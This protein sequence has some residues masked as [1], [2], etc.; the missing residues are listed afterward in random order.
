VAAMVGVAREVRR[1]LR[2]DGTFWLNI[3][4]SY[5]A[6]QLVGIPWRV[7]LALQADG[8][9]LRSDVI[10]AKPNPMPE[11]VTDRPTKAHEYVFLLTKAARYYYDAEAIAERTNG[12]ELFGNTRRL[13]HDDL[14]D[15]DRRDMTENWSRNARSVWTIATSPYPE[16]HFATFPKELP[17]RCIRAGTPEGGACDRC[18]TPRERVLERG[19]R[20]AEQQL[21]SGGSLLGTYDGAPLKDY[22]PS[23]AQVPGEVKARILAGMVEKRT[24]G[25]R[26]ACGC[27]GAGTRPAIVLDPF[28]GS[29]TT[30][31]AAQDLD[32]W[33]VGQEL[34]PEY[35]ALAERRCA[36]DMRPLDLAPW[37]EPDHEGAA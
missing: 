37:T 1:V 25:W 29:G 5:D 21:A 34:N 14:N 22:A 26:R 28:A 18:G 10:W 15:I 11:S 36:R 9:Y 6:K 2:S 7:A 24:V 35:V 23:G 8:W 33:A 19:E 3:G 32:R 31:D 16:A 27:V 12:R 20:L 30:L 4:D 13:S 17:S